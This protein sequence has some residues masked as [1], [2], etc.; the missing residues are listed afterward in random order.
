M[1][2]FNM[3]EYFYDDDGA[4][5]S[6]VNGFYVDEEPVEIG[7]D[8]SYY[9]NHEIEDHLDIYFR[10]FGLKDMDIIY[11]YFLSNK[12]QHDIKDIVCK[13]Q[14]AVSYDV[15][16]IRDQMDFV[17]KVITFMDDFIGFIIDPD[18]GLEL[19]DRELLLVFFYS[20]SIVKTSQILGFGQISCRVK[21]LRAI[22]RV[23][24]LGYDDIYDILTYIANNLNRIKKSVSDE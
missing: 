10:L 18:N 6:I 23:K 3:E 22:E 1:K 11:L 5:A 19:S 16:R 20:T 15:N 2:D 17:V 24:E 21:I 4:G 12:R 7:Y 13:T 9:D 14:P 8:R